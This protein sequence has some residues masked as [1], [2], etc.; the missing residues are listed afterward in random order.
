MSRLSRTLVALAAGILLLSGCGFSGGGG[1][2]GF[3]SGNGAIQWLP[4]AQRQTIGAVS[5]QA[6]DASGAVGSIDLN[7]LKGKIVVV[8]VWGSWCP[9]CRAETPRLEAALLNLRKSYGSEV[10]FVGINTRDNSIDNAVAFDRGF[11]VTYPSI[12]DADGSTL[13]AFQGHVPPNAIPTTIVLDKQGRVAASVSGELTSA[14]TLENLVQD[15]ISGKA[16][17]S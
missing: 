11:G 2:G 4:V 1:G 9:P 5:G 15:V 17:A 8:N 13:L 16:N 12:Y 3:V 10:V 6:F 7:A 14:I